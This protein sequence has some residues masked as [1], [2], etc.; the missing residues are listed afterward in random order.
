[1]AAALK[2]SGLQAAADQKGW[3]KAERTQRHV[4]GLALWVFIDGKRE[5]IAIIIFKSAQNQGFTDG[6]R[7]G[8]SHSDAHE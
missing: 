3:K 5:N 1:M 8:G 4:V 6:G 7:V 2:S